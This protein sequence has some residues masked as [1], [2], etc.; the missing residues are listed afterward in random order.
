MSDINEQSEQL[1]A[2]ALSYAKR[3][4]HVIPVGAGPERKLPLI[5][6]W[7]RAS[8][9]DEEQIRSWWNQYPNANIG[10]ATGPKSG[11]WVV[12]IDMKNGV[13][14]LKSLTDKFGRRF[15]FDREKYIVGKTANGGLHM[16]FQWDASHPVRNAQAVLPGVD[17]RGD[18]GQIVVAPSVRVIDGSEVRYR[19][20]RAELPVSPVPEWARSLADS[21]S[22]GTA[23]RVDLQAVMAG[24]TQGARDTELWRYA[25][26]LAGR[27]VPLDLAL[28]FISVAAERCQPSFDTH[29]AREKVIRAYSSVAPN[30]IS[31]L[32]SEITDEL[33]RRKEEV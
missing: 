8:T 9:T 22:A 27:G 16:L 3:G 29:L 14:G 20:Y 24:L 2:A 25:C 17:I 7:T 5:K 33:N 15:D 12:D 10:V 30:A 19:W 11:F 18:G 28:S 1:L 23:G 13:N 26:H 21:R 32:V 31:N 4:W 6:E